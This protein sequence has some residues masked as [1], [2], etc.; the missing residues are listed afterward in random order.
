MIKRRLHGLLEEP[1]F[2]EKS[3][4]PVEEVY[5]IWSDV[6][7]VCRDQLILSL[8]QINAITVHIW[9]Y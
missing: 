4:W 5:N 7:A 6:I 9:K 8:L 3:E 1:V 2:I